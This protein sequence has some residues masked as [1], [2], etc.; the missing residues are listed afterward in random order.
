VAAITMV[1]LLSCREALETPA[2]AELLT[3]PSDW[4]GFNSI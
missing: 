2:V 4:M 3:D 1:F